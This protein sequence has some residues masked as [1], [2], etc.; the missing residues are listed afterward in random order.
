MTNFAKT[1]PLP[2][3]T[4]GSTNAPRAPWVLVGGSYSGSLAAWTEITA[5]G[6]FWAYHASSAPVQAIEN[7]WEYFQPIQQG[8]PKACSDDI[9]SVI[10]HVDTVLTTGTE[11]ERQALKTMFGLSTVIHDTDFARTLTLPLDLW[12]VGISEFMV[13]C[14][15]LEGVPAGQVSPTTSGIGLAAALPN[16]ASYV[17]STQGCS[18]PDCYDSYNVNQ[19][20]YTNTQLDTGVIAGRQWQWMLCNEAFGFWQTGAPDGQDSLVS[21]LVTAD[22]YQ[23]QCNFYFPGVQ[24]GLTEDAHNAKYMGWDVKGTTRVMFSSGEFDP[25]RSAG[26]SSEFK[27]GGPMVSTSDIP[28]FIVPGGVHTQD[29][30]MPN[31]TPEIAAL[32]I[33]EVAQMKQWIGEFYTKANTTSSSVSSTISSTKTSFLGSSTRPTSTSA[34]VTSSSSSNTITSNS[35]ISSMMPSTTFV[36]P[37][38]RSSG[39]SQGTAPT[40]TKSSN[41]SNNH[42][43]QT[44]AAYNNSTRSYTLVNPTLSILSSS[45]VVSKI[46]QPSNSIS[47]SHSILTTSIVPTAV[48][49][50]NILQS[51]YSLPTTVVTQSIQ[52]VIP[53]AV[54]TVYA[55]ET[56]TITSCHPSATG[57]PATS[58]WITTHL[59]SVSTTVC[60]VT[61]SS[62]SA[63]AQVSSVTISTS[64]L[65]VAHPISSASQIPSPYARSITSPTPSSGTLSM[66]ISTRSQS[67][68]SSKS[69]SPASDTEAISFTHRSRNSSSYN[70]PIASA[71]HASGTGSLRPVTTGSPYVGPQGAYPLPEQASHTTVP[72]Q[73][74]PLELIGAAGRLEITAL[75]LVGLGLL[76]VFIF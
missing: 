9:I 71:P 69:I 14:E 52:R 37:S 73:S 10:T 15:A 45:F 6:T 19:Y 35:T 59:I 39:Q 16:F 32:Q 41:A 58:A 25:W 3:D 12:Q 53:S 34:T 21:R 30:F 49:S 11:V 70:F 51:S 54:S 13:F 68:Q 23:Q 24:F 76:F 65:V 5:P 31:I 74:A 50:S 36:F 48:Q 55:T 42:S 18:A 17:A 2:F 29:L 72:V 47:I 61:I 43:S 38:I 4:T 1:V 40:V 33:L 66:E 75:C 22:Y 62:I 67:N 26:V 56:Y 7:F 46:V 64:I 63:S 8:M 57:C 27:P 44:R 20:I 28:V 60:P